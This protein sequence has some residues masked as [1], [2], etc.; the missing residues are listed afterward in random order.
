MHGNGCNCGWER[1][2]LPHEHSILGLFI[3]YSHSNARAL[4]QC[5]QPNL[6]LTVPDSMV[7]SQGCDNEMR[8]NVTVDESMRGDVWNSL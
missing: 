8:D 4:K 5:A 6:N 3:M 1:D 7:D 2:P